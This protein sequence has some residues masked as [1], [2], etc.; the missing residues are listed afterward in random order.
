V[1]VLPFT[2]YQVSATWRLVSCD[3]GYDNV[4]LSIAATPGAED[5]PEQRYLIDATSLQGPLTRSTF[6]VKYHD[7]SN[8]IQSINTDVE[9]RTAEFVGN[10]VRMAGDILPL[11]TGLPTASFEGVAERRFVDL[12]A[13]GAPVC[14]ED[15]RD[16][17]ARIDRLKIALEGTPE[18]RGANEDV[19][20]ATDEVARLGAIVARLGS[21]VDPQTA[22]RFA[23]A[24]ERLETVT[25]AQAELANQL[26]SALRDVTVSRT[27]RWPE[28]GSVFDNRTPFLVPAEQLAEWFEAGPART[29][30][31]WPKSYLAIRPAAGVVP[32]SSDRE[33]DAPARVGG[34][35]Y[36]LNARGRLLTCRLPCADVGEDAHHTVIEGNVAQLG[37]V[38]VLPVRNP[39]LGSSTFGAQF[40]RDGTLASAG[41]AQRRAPLEQASAIAVD[42]TAAIAPLLDPT[43]RLQRETE[44]LEALRELRAAEEALN[45]A[46]PSEAAAATAALQAENTLLDA[47]ISNLEARITL[48]ELQS[49][50]APR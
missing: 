25:A 34:I 49:R 22:A 35:P 11:V 44:R 20:D 50:L 15:A 10:V 26:A 32:S 6:D 30:D 17:L 37:G 43:Q 12:R 47:Q 19:D 9:D 38:A 27:M 33:S 31:L 18:V 16:A 13:G 14:T 28:S 46:Q 3:K 41:F 23:A 24:L 40:N 39:P 4:L 29:P 5:D 42:T 21:A 2:Q 36:R 1:Q 7:G 8:T 45:P 48:Q